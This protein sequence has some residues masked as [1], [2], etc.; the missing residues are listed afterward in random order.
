MI[1]MLPVLIGQ[2]LVKLRLMG[3][4]ALKPIKSKSNVSHNTGIV[5][6]KESKKTLHLV[7]RS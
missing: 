7:T 6:D 4:I 5:S 2:T 1:W 3:R